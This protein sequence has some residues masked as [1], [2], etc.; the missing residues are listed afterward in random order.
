MEIWRMF[1]DWL[2][3]TKQG[4]PSPLDDLPPPPGEPAHDDDVVEMRRRNEYVLLGLSL[5][6]KKTEHVAEE[7]MRVVRPA[8]RKQG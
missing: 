6:A 1:R 4:E 5:A 7:A 2:R 3:G 8:I